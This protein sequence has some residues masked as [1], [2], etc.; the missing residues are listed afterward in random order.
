[1]DFSLFTDSL[2]CERPAG[3]L[4]PDKAT[5]LRIFPSGIFLPSHKILFLPSHKISILREGKVSI[6]GELHD[7]G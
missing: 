4:G 5:S 2:Y 7:L 1:M 6:L 3:K